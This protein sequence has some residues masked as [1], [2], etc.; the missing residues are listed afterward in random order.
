MSVGLATSLAFRSRG[1]IRWSHQAVIFNYSAKWNAT[2][3]EVG[4]AFG[5]CVEIPT[6]IGHDRAEA[7]VFELYRRFEKCSAGDA[8]TIIFREPGGGMVLQY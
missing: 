7:T 3:S 1:L 5:A 6:Y 2:P 4:T 8:L